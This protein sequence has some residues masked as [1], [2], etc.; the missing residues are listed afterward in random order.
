M[1]CNKD[2]GELFE[3]VLRLCLLLIDISGSLEIL[4]NI[5]VI[6]RTKNIIPIPLLVFHLVQALGTAKGF[7]NLI[8]KYHNCV[9]FNLMKFLHS[10][11]LD[12]TI[13]LL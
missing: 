8:T 1:Q 11:N 6:F 3:K 10:L 9:V 13:W 5:S 2:E 7:I 12:K 4:D